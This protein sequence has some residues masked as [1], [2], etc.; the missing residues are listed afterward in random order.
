M[1]ARRRASRA[2]TL[3]SILAL[4]PLAAATTASAQDA[5]YW[6]YGYGPVGQLTEGTIVGGVNDLSAVFYNPGAT[7]LIKKPR[8]TLTLTSVELSSLKAPSAAGPQLDF[9]STIFDTVPP[10][11]AGRLARRDDAADQFAFAFLSRHNT[12]WDLGYS[13]ANVD[14]GTADAS[15]GFG[16]V[17]ERVLDYW[18]G[19]SWSHRLSDTVSVGVSPFF[20]YRAQRNR[21]SLTV[22]E[23]ASGA[24]AALFVGKEYEYNHVG[25][26][27]KFG[28]AWRPG[29]LELGATVTTPRA[30]IWSDGKTVFNASVAGVPDLPLL[31]ASTQTGLKSTFHSPWS[32]A[33]G[34]TW[35][36]ERTAVHT[37][38]EWFSAI[39]P[40]D[41]LEPQSAPV[42]GSSA[43]IPLTYVGAAKSVVNFGAGL[44]HR[45]G[46]TTTVYGGVARNNSPWRD[47]SETIASW[48]LTDVTGGV[49]FERLGARVAL[50]VGYAWGSETIEP[51]ITPPGPSEPAS[52]S[53][54]AKYHRWTFSVGF[55]MLGSR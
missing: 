7:A 1:T 33:G 45:V 17:R 20:T 27:G 39:D 54:D 47:Q 16:R 52:A 11:I 5:H 13:D 31:S 8:F 36:G 4:S 10:V 42:A 35:R 2:V 41:I 23:Y 50:G 9:D 29:H 19:P 18:V 25:V 43:T 26:L 48:D 44:E 49:S 28:L 6:T 12:D 15:A 34:A 53:A 55:S 40:Y 46:D 22:E 37:T 30:R 32:V 21:R 3:A 38:V 14:G 51:V 24:V